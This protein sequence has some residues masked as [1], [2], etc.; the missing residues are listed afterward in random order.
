MSGDIV[1]PCHGAPLLIITAYTGGYMGMD[2]P[3]E[4][5][6]SHDGCLNSWTPLGIAD[7]WNKP[8]EHPDPFAEIFS[9]TLDAL[10]ALTIRKATP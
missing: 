9:G 7:E 8:A 10:N 5:M 4:I 2:V 3:S 6:C 1:T